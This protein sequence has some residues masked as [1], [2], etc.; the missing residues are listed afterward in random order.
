MVTRP[1]FYSA[2]DNQNYFVGEG[3]TTSRVLNPPGGRSSINLGWDNHDATK[4]EISLH[5]KAALSWCN[6]DFTDQ[7]LYLQTYDDCI[8]LTASN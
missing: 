4:G 5:S 2:N 6:V 3:K 1:A 8:T 7:L